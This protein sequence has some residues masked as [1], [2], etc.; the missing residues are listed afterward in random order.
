MHACLHE[1]NLH[2]PPR[3]EEL[4]DVDEGVG[5]PVRCYLCYAPPGLDL[6]IIFA[7]C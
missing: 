2:L 5:V 6:T 1:E 3:G 4:P 7:R